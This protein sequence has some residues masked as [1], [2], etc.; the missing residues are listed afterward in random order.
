MGWTMACKI[1]PR[2]P[3][4][5]PSLPLQ[6]V[7]LPHPSY[8]SHASEGYHFACLRPTEGN[9]LVLVDVEVK[10]TSSQ[11]I[12]RCAQMY[13][14]VCS[15]PGILSATGHSVC[16]LPCPFTFHCPPALPA[17][18]LRSQNPPIPHI[19]PL[20][21]HL[22]RL[23]A[24]GQWSGTGRRYLHVCSLPCMFSA[25]GLSAPLPSHFPLPT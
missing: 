8:S 24:W 4:F 6:L 11:S 1:R 10:A 7:P 21:S 9:D 17:I 16:A 19:S 23:P 20:A 5:V 12:F 14:H 18:A 25:S 13:L 22:L 15:L 2:I 3:L